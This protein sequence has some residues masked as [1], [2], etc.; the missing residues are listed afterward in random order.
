MTSTYQKNFEKLKSAMEH[1][2][3]LLIVEHSTSIVF[4]DKETKV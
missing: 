3:L 2:K 4:S 1:Q